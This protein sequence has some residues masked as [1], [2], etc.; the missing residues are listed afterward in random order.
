MNPYESIVERLNKIEA[1]LGIEKDKN[2]EWKEGLDLPT[3]ILGIKPYLIQ[4]HLG[5]I[6]CKKIFNRFYF[7]RKELESY[8][9][10]YE[11]RIKALE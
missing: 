5:T 8:L 11:V 4:K 10:N 9:K 6:P 2:L 7:N 3:E 1:Q